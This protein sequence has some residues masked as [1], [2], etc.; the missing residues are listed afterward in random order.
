M[1][2]QYYAR[3]NIHSNPNTIIHMQKIIGQPDMEHF[4]TVGITNGINFESLVA[5]IETMQRHVSVNPFLLSGYESKFK[6]Q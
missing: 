3:V 5:P 2:G 6:K 1:N 4:P